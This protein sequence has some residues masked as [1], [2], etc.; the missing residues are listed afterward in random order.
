MQA[1]PGIVATLLASVFSSALY[2]QSLVPE[3]SPAGE[4]ESRP[5]SVLFYLMDTCRQDRMGFNG[6]ERETTPFLEWLSERSV[7]FEAC[8]SQAPWTKPSMASMLTSRYPSTTGIYRMDQRLSDAFLTWPEVLQANGIYTAGFSTN[9]VMG[10][11]LSNFAQGF[12]HFI[13]GTYIN[14]GDAIHFASGSSR[15]LNEHAFAWLDKNDH[16]PIL[17]YMHSV[18]PHEEYEPAPEFMELFADTERHPRF[19]QEWQ[20]LLRSRPPIPGLYVTQDNFDRTGVNAASF[21]EHASNLYDADI[22]ANDDQ[23]QR[24]WDKLQKKGWGQDFVFVFT[25]DHGEEFFEHGAT[26][27]GYS[28]YD[29]MIRVPLM[30]YAPGLLT[31]G[32]R[33]DT[34]V[35]S[36]DIYPTLCELLGFEVEEG[37]QGQSLLPLLQDELTQAAPEVFSEHKEDPGLRAMG[38]GSGVM[39]SVRSGKWKF[40]LNIEGSQLLERPRFELYDLQIDPGEHTNVAELNTDVAQRFEGKALAFVA[41]QATA[42]TELAAT[43][44]A[45]ADPEALE[46]LRA[47]GYVGDEE[48][49]DIWAAL[50]SKD[51]SQIR[52]ALRDGASPNQMEPATGLRPLAMAAL[53][54]NLGLAKV[55]VKAGA[56]INL[57]NRDGSRPLSGAAFLGCVDMLAYLLE[58]GADPTLKSAIGDTALSATEVPWDFTVYIANLLGIQLEKPAVQEGRKHCAELLREA[59]AEDDDSTGE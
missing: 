3:G 20:K 6:Y 13:E 4:A 50:K 5:R 2:S 22:L 49:A 53:L 21:I 8:Y 57:A 28:L 14:R 38:H 23:M 7:V 43:E 41:Q 16:W 19:R 32:T 46:Q 12:D 9:I 36:I 26:S 18:D 37:L 51:F 25:S 52:R 15:K 1:P 55:L 24:L 31:G 56:K 39:V 45:A 33:V 17:L 54:G 47:L 58:E 44:L 34:P 42:A 35:R 10:N 11:S 40:I 30:I 29:E 48:E 27:H 59:L